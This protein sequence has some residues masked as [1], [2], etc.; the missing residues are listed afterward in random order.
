[1]KGDGITPTF[2]FRGQEAPI[3]SIQSDGNLVTLTVK[4]DPLTLL[5][6]KK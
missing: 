2:K 3:E 1:M 6:K 5:P 4:L